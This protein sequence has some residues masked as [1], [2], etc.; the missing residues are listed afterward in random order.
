MKKINLIEMLQGCSK[1][2]GT[3]FR[4]S[5]PDGQPTVNRQSR[6]MLRQG[7]LRNLAMIFAVLVMSIA[8]I[9]MAWGASVAEGTYNFVNQTIGA[10]TKFYKIDNGIYQYRLNAYAKNPSLGIQLPAPSG[11]GTGFVFHLEST[12]KV[13]I[14]IVKKSVKAE[15]VNNLYI[16]TITEANFSAIEAGTNNNTTVTLSLAG[17][18]TLSQNYTFAAIGTAK[19]EGAT[20]YM[21]ELPAGYYYAYGNSTGGNGNLYSISFGTQTLFLVPN[22]KTSDNAKFAIYYWMGASGYERQGW[23][24]YMTVSPCNSSTYRADIPKGYTK[25]I[26]VRLNPSGGRNWDSK[27]NK[28]GDLTFDGS[29]DL[30]TWA[31]GSWDDVTTTWSASTKYTISFAANGGSGSMSNVSS[32]ACGRSV[33]IAANAYEKS[34]FT[35]TG[36]KANVD[37]KVGGSTKTAGT[38]LADGVTIQDISSNITLTAQWEADAPSCSA[39][40]S[41]SISGT[42]SYT[43]GDDISLTASATGTSGSTTYTWYKG[44]DW[45]T[46]SG[47]TPV[48][49]EST[50]GATFTKASCV[51][52]DA[53][54]YWCNISNGTGCEAQVSKTITVSAALSSEKKLLGLKFS[55]GFD[56]FINESAHTVTAYYLSGTDAPTVT[57]HTE[58][59]NASYSKA[60]NT[61]TIT[62]EDATTQN[63]TLTLTTVTPYG[64]TGEVESFNGSETYVKGGL[65]ENSKWTFR[66]NSGSDDRQQ[67]GLNRLY[68]FIDACTTVKLTSGGDN[69]AVKVYRNGTELGSP[70]ASGANNA[71]IDIEGSVSPALYAIVSNQ[72]SG[73]GTF[74]AIQILPR[75]TTPA[76]PTNFT[77][78]SISATGATFT[79][80]DAG[81]AASYDIYYS[82]SSSTPGSS[83]PATT[84][85]TSK[86]KEITGLT[87]ATTYY[88]WVRSVCDASHK[89]AWVALNPGE[90]THTFATS[91]VAPT[92]VDI[93]ATVNEA[94]GYWFYPGDDVVLTATPTGSPAGSPVTYQWKKNGADI[95]GATSSTYTINDAEASDAGK[96]TCTISYGA[97]STTSAEFE[98]KCMQFYLK[99]SGGS[100]ISNHALTKVDATHATLSLS[101]T[102]GTT[103]N[104]RVTDGCNNWYGN[105]DATGM[106]SSNCSNWTMPHDADCKVTTSSKSATYTFNFDFSAGLLGSEMKVSVVY[107]AGDQAEGKVIYWDNSVLNWASAPW[108]RIGKGTHNNKTQMTLVPGTANL[109]KITTAEYNG[110]EYWH[111][112]NNEGE[113]TGNIFWTKDSD[114]ATNEA[115]TAA[116]GFEGSPVTADAVTFTPTSSHGMGTSPDNDNCD[117]Y[118]YGQ[119][120]GMKTDRVTISPYSNG[121]ITVNYT[122]TSNVASTLT[123]GYADLAHTVI[124]TSITAVANTGY[125][126]G[127]I[128]I[129]AG[130]YSANHVVTGPTTIAATFTATNY[131]IAYDLAGGSVASDNPTSYTIESE[132]I[133]LNNP[134]KTGYTFAGWTG[135]GLA[136]ATTTVTIAAGSTGNR[137]YTATWSSTAPA[138][139]CEDLFVGQA[140]DKSTFTASTGSA[141]TALGSNGGAEFSSG[142]YSYSVKP[143]STNAIVASPKAGKS[144]AAG[145]SLIFVVYNHNDGAKEMGFTL[146]SGTTKTSVAASTLHKFR[147]KL[148]ASDIVDGKVTFNRQN[149]DDRWVAITIKHCEAASC[150]GTPAAPTSPTNGATTAN[151]QAVSWIDASNEKWDVIV[152]TSSSTPDAGDTPTASNLTSKS[153]TFTGLTASTTYY[154]WVRSVCDASHKSAWVA[155]TNFETSAAGEDPIPALISYYLQMPNKSTTPASLST[156]SIITTPARLKGDT[157]KNFV[158]VTLGSKLRITGPGKDEKNSKYTAKIGKVPA[159]STTT[160][161]NEIKLAFDVHDDYELNISSITLTG[162]TV[163]G[164][165]TLTYRAQISDGVTSAVGR[166]ATTGGGADRTVVFES[167]SGKKFSGTVTL[168][169]W[170][171]GVDSCEYRLKSPIQIDGTLTRKASACTMPTQTFT[172]GAYTLG[173]AAL[174]LSSLFSSNSSGAVT[175]SVVN[176]GGTSAAIVGSSFTASNAGTATIRANQAADT[177]GG[178]NYCAKSIETTITVS[179]TCTPQSL[180]KVSAT[181]GTSG[182]VTGYNDGQYAGDAVVNLYSKSPQPA[183]LSGVGDVD[184]YK[185]GD[186]G[187]SIV[188]ATLKGTSF[189]EGDK[190]KIGITRRNDL[191][192]VNSK[193]NILTIYYGTDKSDAAALT[194]ITTG[195]DNDNGAT[196]DEGAGFYEYTLTDGDVTTI[197]S[198]KGIGLFRESGDN[199]ENPYVYSV[200][201][202]GCREWAVCPAPNAVAA[203]DA[204]HNSAVL[205]VTDAEETDS[206]EFYYST[207]STAPTASTAATATGSS[208][209]KTITGLSA[210][211]TYY[212]WVRSNCGDVTKSAWV[213]GTPTSFTTSAAA[214]TYSVTYN[215]NGKTG[216]D[217]PTDATAYEEGD[218]VTVLGN[219]GSL[220]K[221]GQTF[222][223]WSTNSTPASGIFYPVGYKFEMPDA[224]V[225]LYAV[226]GSG[227]DCITITD[228]ETS[229][230]SNSS[231]N[232]DSEG[233]Y[234]YGY[235]G[236]KDAAHAVTITA[237]NGDCIG[238]NSGAN[239]KVYGGKYV[240]IYADNTTTGGTPSTFTNVTS[241]SIKAKVLNA[242]YIATFDIMVGSTTIADN[243][244]LSAATSAFQTYSYS[245]LNNLSG[246]IKIINNNGGSSSYSFLVDD[247]EICTGSG[248]SGYTVSF[249]MKDHGSAI[250]DI[251][252]V[253]SGSKIGAPLPEPTATD[254]DFGGWYKETECTNEWNFATDAVSANTT[255]YAK[256][257]NCAPTITTHPVAANY[258]QNGVASAL[259]VEAAT[260]GGDLHYQWWVKENDLA[261]EDGSVIPGATGISFTP[262]TEL[263]GTRYYYCVVSNDCGNVKTNTAAVTI[264]DTKPDPTAVWDVD[265][266]TH[267]GKGFTFS[268]IAKNDDG[269]DLWDG[270][271]TEEMLSVSS[272]A[273]LGTVTVN[274]ETKTISGTYGVKASATSPVTFYLL[275]PATETFAAARLDHDQSFTECVGG[276]G[277][278]HDIRVLKANKNITFGGGTVYGWDNPGEGFLTASTGGTVSTA[279]AGTKME[280]VFDTVYNT[281]KKAFWVMP[282]AAGIKKIKVY[283]DVRVK[284]L[285]V[286]NV[287]KVTSFTSGKDANNIAFSAAYEGGGDNVASTGYHWFEIILEDALD[288]NDIIYFTVS[289]NFQISGVRVT[290]GTSSGSLYTSLEWSNSD[291]IAG[292]VNK[293]E[294]DADF[295]ITATRS[296]TNAVNSNASLGA[297]SYNS[298][299]PEVATVDAATGKIHIVA[300]GTTDIKATLAASGCYKKA[301]ITYSLVVAEYVCAEAAG[302]VIIK[303]EPDCANKVLT[304]T[305]FE[306]GATTFQWYKDGE[307]ITGAISQDYTA[308]ASGTYSVSTQKTCAVMSANSIT[309]TF[310]AATATKIVDEWYVKNDRRTPDIALVQTTNATGFTVTTGSPASDI[311]STG[312][313]GCTF[314]LKEDGIIYLHG[315]TS[316][317]AAPSGMTPGDMTITITATACS[318]AAPL[319]IVLHI[320]PETAKPTIA[321]VVDG[322][323]RKDGGTATSVLEAKTSERPIWKYLAN[324]FA[325]TGCNAYWSVDSKE[326]RQYYSQFDAILITD[327]PNTSTSG[328]GG[329]SYVK[330]FGTMVDVRP[331][332]TL[333]AYVGKFKDGGWH[334]YDA[335]PTSPNP[336]QVEMKL[337]CKNHDIFRGLDPDASANVRTTTDEYGNEYWHV[338]MVDTTLSPYHNTKDDYEALPALQGFDR[339][340]FS[341]MLG[342]GTIFGEKLQAGVE[343]QEEPA[344]RMMILGV[345]NNAMAALTNEGK[346]V[347]KNALEYLLKTNMEDV[348]DCSNYFTNADGDSQWGNGANW[349]RGEVPDFETRARILKPV[350]IGDGTT[351]IAARVDIAASGES[352]HVDGECNGSVTI[353]PTGALIVG[354]KIRRADAPRYGID[355]LMPTENSDLIVKASTTAPHNQGALIF[356]NTDGDTHAVVEMWNPSHWEMDGGKK[357]KYWS[358][359]AVPIQEAD[360]P[361]FFWYGFTYLYDETSGWIKKGDGTVL[362]PF[363][364]IGASLQTGNMETFYGPLATT[365][366]QDITLT[367]T[368]GKGQGMNLIGNSWT[369]PIQIA[370]FEEDDFGDATAEVWVFNTGHTN[371]GHTTVTDGSS[372]TTTAGQW[373]TIP[374][375]IAGLN[376]YT[377]LKVI[378]A[379]QAFEVNTATATTLHLDYDRLV[380][381]GRTN[382]N[383]PMRAPRRSAAKQIEATMRVRVSGELT[384]TDVYLL[385][386]ARFSDAFDNGWDGHYLSGDDRSAQLYAISEEEGKLAFLAQPEIEGTVL[387]FA[388]S[389][390]GNEYTFSFSYDGD[391][392]Y[393]L[394]DL[395][396]TSSTLISGENSYMF[397]YEEGDTN[398]FYISRQPLGA[399]AITTGVDEVREEAKPRK[400]IYNDK[401]YILFNGRVFDATGKVVK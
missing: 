65:W 380:R 47:T 344:A 171:W 352:K 188:F 180:S 41:P 165:N 393:Y 130:A 274:D 3:T 371:D 13:Y 301:E 19:T 324:T 290:E 260:N 7:Y 351:A 328:T 113:G 200:E 377:G 244:S 220:V 367:V 237:V 108:Y 318:N 314:E 390:D 42:T 131:T 201:I 12:Q 189:Q 341:N 170:V 25:V 16:K 177:E 376:T 309:L 1:R 216:G 146:G 239:L 251:A 374:I 121:T 349:T 21:G 160:A 129:N 110:F 53:G 78:G 204:T 222:L 348:N 287:R 397:T 86:T 15:V 45:A 310:D 305:G 294:G 156:D 4:Q 288:A 124:L 262:S 140:T 327:D 320:Q 50:S 345:Q 34:G 223:G 92:T 364:G 64:G 193:Y 224:A 126:A 248:A 52:G 333:E 109:Y 385:K 246:K 384:H 336:R 33:V 275:L 207:S 199:G 396:L 203:S 257:S 18:A 238:Q 256:W 363:Q 395:K 73:N 55:N 280:S 88:A 28:T 373:Q 49:A 157:L 134:T 388:P 133:T 284:E 338:I 273:V 29:K 392:E 173:G 346:L 317:G 163:G 59:A 37:V 233:K 312:I 306:E 353:N 386:D 313:G 227:S 27:W 143:N 182:T 158:P 172:A 24:D 43:A 54:T 89:S 253:P 232:P 217:V 120:N 82:T 60:G 362:Y 190:V 90:D 271:L 240:N 128:T 106:T 342:V 311:T 315:T 343:R 331:V 46:A 166:I 71:V 368:A 234:F 375:G 147:I 58:S 26:F 300:A 365:E 139:D 8:N 213:A 205:T 192:Q 132:A 323:L 9:G 186:A 226:W 80:T 137:S 292:T 389:K 168:S 398:R 144:F 66:K 299:K 289:E 175:Y 296:G 95:D 83:T 118:E 72:T 339:T 211:T 97:C 291:A 261:D 265:E 169:L 185:M 68:F 99:N 107:P 161:A 295:S 77:A 141:T 35:F 303:S 154:W 2:N 332:L 181:K 285:V 197:G 195:G 268:V 321:F 196:D 228:F 267:G 79:I 357:K 125:D 325:L 69:R 206:Y 61:I 379:M 164:G 218:V 145:D 148:Q 20:V 174:N 179:G 378:P 298:S 277:S 350:I 81:N 151:T 100:D 208:L 212:Y 101:L 62:A 286:S 359:V 93:S 230:H 370:N 5:N 84:T 40:T 236:T 316:T 259:T 293:N 279:K 264:R 102:G 74:K 23:S 198:K 308:T 114:P 150:D 307:V 191:R 11:D 63:Y 270:T 245:G 255:L 155:G 354:G 276:D 366:S 103:Y 258:N 361:N 394:N 235:K 149:G 104:F 302:T 221:T 372:G 304:V 278:T 67:Q 136:E 30:F 17:S 123:S 138:G 210:S 231:N 209:T 243:V 283:G 111:I 48:Q 329:V 250:A 162:L 269:T 31:N 225:N 112:A 355:D 360:I 87:A 14:G 241:V 369:A 75:C 282:Y 167:F 356:N 401:M 105:S 297:I 96:Y 117:F 400:F 387:G 51:V 358:Y 330:A 36:W 347:I 56:A 176:A 10:A 57:S 194:T 178:H 340:K 116:M 326:L 70:T 281:N 119:Q 215:G 252:N 39:P 381:T 383:E 76:A 115:I 214:S 272:E 32:I 399:P 44:A 254:W 263:L 135:T 219:T 202:L 382:L 159:D 6:L 127:A 335:T 152:S 85:S 184:G 319:N 183:S 229:S 98:L 91:C 242:S 266:P 247:I 94:S 322:T 334:V 122:N 249:D 187:T 22:D 391:E 38:L 153:Y 142:G 337:E